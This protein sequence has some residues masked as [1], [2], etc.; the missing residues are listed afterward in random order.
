MNKTAKIA[1][2][3]Q[4]YTRDVPIPEDELMKMVSWVINNIDDTRVDW[5]AIL[6]SMGLLEPEGEDNE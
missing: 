1:L 3:L 5:G 4:Y 6:T 2:L